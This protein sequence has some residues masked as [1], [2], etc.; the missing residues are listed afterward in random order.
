MLK[1]QSM[2]CSGIWLQITFQKE[3]VDIDSDIIV[4]EGQIRRAHIPQRWFSSEFQGCPLAV[5]LGSL[6]KPTPDKMRP[7]LLKE[8]EE[9]FPILHNA[10][11]W[12]LLKPHIPLQKLDKTL[13]Q[14]RRDVLRSVMSPE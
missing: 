13:I 5:R 7:A 10:L 6:S 1:V 9:G 8:T 2:V 4:F 11:Q 3:V 14:E 12:P